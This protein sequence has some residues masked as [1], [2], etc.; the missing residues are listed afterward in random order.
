MNVG[1]ISR[2]RPGRDSD[3]GEN[4]SVY[5]WNLASAGSD[6]NFIAHK[7][8]RNREIKPFPVREGV[9]TTMV[10]V[11][12]TPVFSLA[13][14]IGRWSL[15]WVIENESCGV[16]TNEGENGEK[17]ENPVNEDI[18]TT[19]RV[20]VVTKLGKKTVGVRHDVWFRRLLFDRILGQACPRL[21]DEFAGGDVVDDNDKKRYCCKDWG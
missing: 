12:L 4:S 7:G 21:F 18:Q 2:P 13:C 20:S 5:L 9:S 11:F 15:I 1:C 6:S 19:K 8:D 10:L 17:A 3:D 14:G 16:E